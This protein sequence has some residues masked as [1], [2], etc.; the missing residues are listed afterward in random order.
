MRVT[1]TSIR[2]IA[3]LSGIRSRVWRTGPSARTLDRDGTVE[4]G[5]A[6]RSRKGDTWP[7]NEA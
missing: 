4:I 7:K 1:N 5:P 2:L 3:R 6:Q